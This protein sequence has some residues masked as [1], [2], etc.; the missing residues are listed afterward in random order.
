MK[1]TCE[2]CKKMFDEK[3]NKIIKIKRPF[4]W[5]FGWLFDGSMFVCEGCLPRVIKLKGIKNE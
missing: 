3:S 1:I 2:V 4:G 5:G